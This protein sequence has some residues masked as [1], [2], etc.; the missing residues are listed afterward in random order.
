[1]I[2]AKDGR[3]FRETQ[4]R[5]LALSSPLGMI[6]GLFQAVRMCIGS[7]PAEIISPERNTAPACRLKH[8]PEEFGPYLAGR[9]GPLVNTHQI[10]P[11]VRGEIGPGRPKA[12]DISKRGQ[13]FHTPSGMDVSSIGQA[14][15]FL[16]WKIFP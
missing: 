8:G 12:Y 3:N 6:S 2:F 4:T 13:I 1:M 10:H 11:E 5:A 9:S 14:W 15:K 16:Q 7:N